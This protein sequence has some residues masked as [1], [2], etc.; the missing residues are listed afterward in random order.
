MAYIKNLDEGGTGDGGYTPPNP[1]PYQPPTAAPPTDPYPPLPASGPISTQPVPIPPSTPANPYGALPTPAAYSPWTDPKYRIPAS[2]G[3][4]NYQTVPGWMNPNAAPL[5]THPYYNDFVAANPGYTPK[6]TTSA[7]DFIKQYQAGHPVS[8]GVQPLYAAM[9]A[10]GYNVAPYMYGAT[11]S[12]NEITLDGQKYKVLGGEGTPWA[13]WYSAGQNDSG[14]GGSANPFDDPATKPYIDQLLKRIQEL[15]LPQ[16]NPQMDSLQAYLKKYFE[17]LQGPTYTPQQQD[18]I[19]TQAL[20]PLQRQRQAELQQ[21]ALTM[22]KRGITPGSGPYLQA[23]R[24]I[25]QKFDSLGAQTQGGLALNEINLGRENQQQAV[26]VG[27]AA[28]QLSNGQFLQQENR[29]NQALNFGSQIPQ[30]AQQRMAQAIQLLNSQNQS[31]GM[32]G[33]LQALEGFQ[34][35]GMTQN[36]TDSSYWSNLIALLAKQFGL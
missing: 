35:N 28:A 25:N 1:P 27:S 14:L 3:S 6:P 23:E 29:A 9:K 31:Q 30:L 21:V 19:H 26:N 2:P 36:A 17:Q 8:E 4:P 24:D 12:N 15:Q 34:K 33:L 7:A 16:Q 13:Y 22:A 32:A 18:T 11:Q 10:A 5:P 20:D